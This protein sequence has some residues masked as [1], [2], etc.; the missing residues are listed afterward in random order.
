MVSNARRLL[1]PGLLLAWLCSPLP[2][3]A[4][5]APDRAA[6]AAG[7][8]RHN[9][10]DVGFES[11]AVVLSGTLYLPLTAGPHPAVVLVHGS[12]PDTREPYRNL[13]AHFARSGVAALVYDKRGTGRSTGD[14]RTAGFE[15]LAEDAIAAVRL[16]RA[17]G[18]IATERVGLWGI[19]QG[20]WILPLAASQAPEIAFIIPVSASGVSPARQEMWRVGNNLRY[21]ELSAAAIGI[22]L[23]GTQMLYSLKPLH[24]RG[25]L[26]LPADL[27]FVALDPWLDPAPTWER[28]RQ[29]VL[30]IW[31]EIDGLVPT[32]ESVEVVRSALERGGNRRYT[33]RVHSGADHGILRAVEGFQREPRDGR[34]YAEGYL[35]GMSKWIHGLDGA[36]R[37]MELVP[38]EHATPTRLSWQRPADP[39]APVFGRAASQIPLTATMVLIFAGVVLALARL[40]IRRRLSANRTP[41]SGTNLRLAA[42]ASA[43]ALVA[44]AGWAAT[45]AATV[46]EG[47]SPF[48]RG[49]PLSL[50]IGRLA[51]TGFVVACVVLGFRVVRRYRG[52]G[53]GRLRVRE[54]LAATVGVT[55][56]I[57]SAYWHLLPFT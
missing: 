32:G 30:A 13:A 10:V 38:A 56:I 27:W 55:F 23:K 6:A 11:G 21:R 47:G 8:D 41:S 24:E 52:S 48:L 43:L 29:P 45:L 12:G 18:A 54:L 44:M 53:G 57:W 28:V 35:E 16:L 19:S 20:G 39:V 22:G 2:S 36:S 1:V 51:A 14:W 25:W 42:L 26:T 4:Q 37:S 34:S 40:S 15:A 3:G 7:L 31:G 49:D 9:A 5:Q 46:L 50:V 33:L 17:H